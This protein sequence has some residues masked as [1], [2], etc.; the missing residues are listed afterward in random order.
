VSPASFA[1]PRISVAAVQ[2]APVFLDRDATVEI[3]ARRTA[4]AA[5]Q[6]AGLVAFPEAFVPGFPTWAL[7]LA[8]TQQQELSA[9][10]YHQ[11]V[12]VPGPTTEALGAI[13]ADHGVVLSVGVTE[14]SRRSVGTMWNANLLFD[15]DGTLVNHR[16]K[17]VPTWAEKLVWA[18]GDGRDLVAAETAAGRVGVLICGENTNPLARFAMIDSGEQI[19]VASYPPAWPTRKAG[20]AGAYDLAHAITVRS[21]AHSF[22]GKL[23]TVVA[24]AALGAAE[25]EAVARLD[26][27]AAEDLAAA[28]TPVSAVVGPTGRVVGEPL[29]GG[30]GVLVSTV[31]LSAAVAEKQIHDVSGGY[32]RY[33]VFSFSV[34]RR[35]RDEAAD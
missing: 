10:L 4:E 1:F 22:E 31:D 8:P 15:A 17:L 7:V 13:A 16:R 14:R 34:D 6:G 33:D 28:A 11:A 30:E 35:R 2:A 23:V 27:S 9:Q 32:Q 21:A 5:A 12:D 26:A 3:V 29:V 20:R 24:S 18:N 19:H 25:V